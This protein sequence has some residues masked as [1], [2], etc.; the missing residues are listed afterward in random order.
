MNYLTIYYWKIIAWD[1]HHINTIGPTW[2]FTTINSGSGGNGDG[3]GD[4]GSDTLNKKPIAELNAGEP[5]NGLV[6]TEITFD[7]SN[8]NDSDGTITKWFWDFGDNTSGTGKITNHSFSKAG[9]YTITLIV[10]DNKGATNKDTS[11]SVITQPNRPPT[12]PTITGSIN[13]TKNTIYTYTAVSIDADNDSIRYA[14]D[15][16]DPLSFNQLSG[17][18]PNGSVFTINHSW[19][20]AGRYKV[21]VTVTDNHTTSSSTITVYID[22]VQT[23]DIGYLLDN[24]NDG[25]YD[26]FYS[27]ASKQITTVQEQN[28]N[29]TIDSDGD[30]DW[31]YIFSSTNELALSQHLPPDI[32]LIFISGTLVLVSIWMILVLLWKRKSM[33]KRKISNHSHKKH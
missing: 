11:I 2:H 33:K 23:G 8:S 7:G 27:D 31:D 21:T 16:G 9:T 15:W 13:G 19:A 28:G 18:L 6:N 17:F 25:I 10:T 12:T 4:G 32:G 22:A 5:Y 14:F 1:S 3:G 30:G 24:N 20:A 26:A 29:Y